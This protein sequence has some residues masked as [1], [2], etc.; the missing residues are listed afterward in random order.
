MVNKGSKC[1]KLNKKKSTK[2]LILSRSDFNKCLN[3][4][5]MP[6][7]V[8]LGQEGKPITLF[9]KK[10]SNSHKKYS[11]YDKEFK[12]IISFVF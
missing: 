2:A 10:L 1:F 4:I 6:I 12:T 9:S 11:I 8:V 3:L 7:G 5:V